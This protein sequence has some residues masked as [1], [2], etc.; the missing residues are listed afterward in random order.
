M[1]LIQQKIDNIIL[2]LKQRP[3]LERVRFVREY[4]TANI[5]TPLRG[6]LAVVSLSQITREKGCIGGYLSSSVKGGRYSAK[7]EISLYAPADENG[8]GL[9]EVI[10]EIIAGL[11]DA[12]S[13]HI[14]TDATASPIEFDA[15]INAIFRRV[16]F[17]IAF[18]LCGEE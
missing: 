12:D 3:E 10:G 18:Y 8:S 15:N 2:R 7:A 13:E 6:M 9:S 14:I 1:T 11:E 17:G 5:E 4:G 16:T